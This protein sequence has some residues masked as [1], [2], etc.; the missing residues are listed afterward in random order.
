MNN[1][2]DVDVKKKLISVYKVINNSFIPVPGEMTTYLK[3]TVS[4]EIVII[5]RTDYRISNLSIRDTLFGLINNPLIVLELKILSCCDNV[6][7][8]PAED[9]ITEDCPQLL[10]VCKSYISPHSSCKII[11]TVSFSAVIGLL[12][13]TTP[14]AP[15][16]IIRELMNSIIIDG[17]VQKISK[18]GCC[19]KTVG[20]I[21]TINNSS[22]LWA[23][24]DGVTLTT[25]YIPP[26]PI[27]I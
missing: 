1:C 12:G 3:L 24:K 17:C 5:N 20:N 14:K 21:N 19:Y 4:Y 15:S 7:I 13:S 22:E 18:C 27:D 23:D 10:D 26:L 11:I 25:K 8:R 9:I 16:P 6:V 2:T